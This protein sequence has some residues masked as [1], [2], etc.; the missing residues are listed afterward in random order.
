MRLLPFEAV[1]VSSHWDNQKYFNQ[2]HEGWIHRLN[3][4]QR[5]PDYKDEWGR[6]QC[7]NC[8][9]FVPLEGV[10]E[11]D[12]GACSNEKS[13]FDKVVMFEHDGCSDYAYDPSYDE[14]LPES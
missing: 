12:Y 2:T 3:R 14:G 7:F 11:N 10:F 8:K 5:D 9:F 13:E 4:T 6:Q 1:D